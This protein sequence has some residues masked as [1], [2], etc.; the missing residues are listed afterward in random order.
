M[1]GDIAASLIRDNYTIFNVYR[2]QSALTGLAKTMCGSP[3]NWVN[4]RT[5]AP[6]LKPSDGGWGLKHPLDH[7]VA[8]Y[9]GARGD[10]MRIEGPD[11]SPVHERTPQIA[12][13]AD[14]DQELMNPKADRSQSVFSE[15]IYR[16]RRQASPGQPS[17]L[18][19]ACL[20][21]AVDD[22]YDTAR[23]VMA[24][25]RV[26]MG[27]G[28]M[29]GLPLPERRPPLAN[30]QP[31]GLRCPFCAKEMAGHKEWQAH[32]MLCSDDRWF[33]HRKKE[34]YFRH[35]CVK[36][37]IINLLGTTTTE[38][39][40]E[41]QLDDG[42]LRDEQL[43]A[44]VAWDEMSRLRKE[45]LPIPQNVASMARKIKQAK[46][47]SFIQTKRDQYADYDIDVIV[48]ALTPDGRHIDAAAK[49]LVE[50]GEEICNITGAACFT[51]RQAQ[52]ALA[53]GLMTWLLK[54]SAELRRAHRLL[55][56]TNSVITPPHI[57]A[58][59][60]QGQRAGAQVPPAG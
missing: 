48:V 19:A 60:R 10:L 44:K 4:A 14:T 46:A 33:P 30:G 39:S 25:H 5:A 11:Y 24:A 41:E 23:A 54:K 17:E 56:L 16:A 27:T 2:G 7:W 13:M 49:E 47:D 35:D 51:E 50:I 3:D 34:L 9:L 18:I 52:A 42:Y 1:L 22:R 38:V 55:R 36:N 43:C 58:A 6:W 12:H 29:A 28:L 21:I 45:N 40:A 32:A 57:P 37:R 20:R 53:I 8:A 59:A 31:G 15:H 26:A